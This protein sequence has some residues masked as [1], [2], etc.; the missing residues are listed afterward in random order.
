MVYSVNIFA[1]AILLATPHPDKNS[2]W[3][4][5]AL[6]IS[7]MVIFLTYKVGIANL[8]QLCLPGTLLST[9][10]ILT[11]LFFVTTLWVLLLSPF[12]RWG[13]RDTGRLINW[14]NGRARHGKVDAMWALNQVFFQW[15]R[16]ASLP[17]APASR[18]GHVT[19]SGHWNV[20]KSGEGHFSGLAPPIYG[21][22]FYALFLSGWKQMTP[23]WRATPWK[24]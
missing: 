20:G 2:L 22:V 6:P 19:D 4:A 17:T 21:M 7:L 10:H 5:I 15:R 3:N 11:H 16:K 23:R 12:Y 1:G 18:Q 24:A 13:N 8:L 14:Q 9:L